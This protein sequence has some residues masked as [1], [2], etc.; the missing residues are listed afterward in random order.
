MVNK[1]R[2]QMTRGSAPGR[3][4]NLPSV[5]T[6]TGTLR[7]IHTEVNPQVYRPLC[8]LQMDW[9][10]MVSIWPTADH[11]SLKGACI[12]TNTHF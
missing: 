9:P 4:V 11:H 5:R 2:R 3:D 7:Y 1:N 8:D 10:K 12:H 6:E